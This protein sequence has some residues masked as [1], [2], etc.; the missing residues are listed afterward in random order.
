[1]QLTARIAGFAARPTD[2]ASGLSQPLAIAAVTLL[3]LSFHL[4]GAKVFVVGPGIK[5][6]PWDLASV[7]IAS[8]WI[9]HFLRHGLTANKAIS[10]GI[11]LMLLFISWMVVQAFRSPVHDRAFTMVLLI[12]RDL[13]LF[14]A[15]ATFIVHVRD[16]RTLNRAVFILGVAVA[17]VSI[18]LYLANLDVAREARRPFGNIILMF[19]GQGF[20]RLIGFARDPNFYA[21]FI[22]VSLFL[23]VAEAHMDKLLKWTGVAIITIALILT[24]SRTAIV[25]VPLSVML[26]T[27][28]L[29]RMKSGSNKASFFKSVMPWLAVLLVVMLVF[30]VLS[31]TMRPVFDWAIYRFVNV[32]DS[33]RMDL[34][35]VL[36]DDPSVFLA[37]QGLRSAVVA[38]EGH[39]A[40]NSY[41]D[42]LFET[43]I[44]GLILWGAFAVYIV[45]K[46]IALIRLKPM[47]VPW[48]QTMFMVMIMMATL[49]IT[50]HPIFWVVSAVILGQ[51]SRVTLD[52][53]LKISEESLHSND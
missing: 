36:V 27:V 51:Y 8:A 3:F 30:G 5:V 28:L 32:L 45:K 33:P 25:A 18:V 17:L 52:N 35:A 22:S 14:V 21:M 9:A 11:A 46:G 37:G 49:S 40:H 38:L 4:W 34:W 50:Y 48:L 47:A 29:N 6:A 15:I 20:P 7:L 24:L 26:V 16:I 23:G 10:V 43:G 1:M 31:V 2:Y 41:L 44:L 42:I 19:G 39:S 13:V 53:R 12:L